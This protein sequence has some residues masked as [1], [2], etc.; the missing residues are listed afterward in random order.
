MKSIVLTLDSTVEYDEQEINARLMAWNREIAPE[1]ECDYVTLRRLLVD[2][3]ELERTADGGRYRVGFPVRPVAFS[4]EIDALDQRAT[5]AAYRME[6]AR[7][8]RVRAPR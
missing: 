5:V 4:L 2:Y 7:R 1:I 8:R 6:Q 3:G